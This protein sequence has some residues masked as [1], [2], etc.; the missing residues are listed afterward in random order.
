MSYIILRSSWCVIFVLNVHAPPENKVENMK[1]RFCEELE[2]VLDIFLKKR[3][4]MLLGELNAKIGRY[5]IFEAL[6]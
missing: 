5:D 3:I 2:G 1:S 6:L 4:K